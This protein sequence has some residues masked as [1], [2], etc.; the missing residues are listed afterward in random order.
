MNVGK[1]VWPKTIAFPAATLDGSWM[2]AIY[3]LLRSR[4]ASSPLA[5]AFLVLVWIFQDWASFIHGY[6][7]SLITPWDPGIGILFALIVRGGIF[8]GLPLL[9]G[10][11]CAEFIVR[12]A[13]LGVPM[14][15]ISAAVIA[16]TYTTAAMIARYHF[17]IDVELTRLRDIMILI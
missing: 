4:A 9:A 7:G 1:L 5:M 6:K 14:T 11:I 13:T 3:G 16:S 17:R 2:S 8:H 15:L 10:I 12:Q